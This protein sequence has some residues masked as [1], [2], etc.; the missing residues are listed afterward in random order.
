[1]QV[2]GMKLDGTEGKA[3]VKRLKPVKRKRRAR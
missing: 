1:V 3:A 2:R